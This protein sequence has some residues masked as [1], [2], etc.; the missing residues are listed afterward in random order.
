M[1]PQRNIGIRASNNPVFSGLSQF[2]RLSGR[3][4]TCQCRWPRFH[5]WVGKTPWRRKWQPAPVFLARESHGQRSLVGYSPWDRK[6]LDMTERTCSLTLEALHTGNPWA[7]TNGEDCSPYWP[8]L[9]AS[10]DRR[11]G[12]SIL[13]CT[14]DRLSASEMRIINLGLQRRKTEMQ[15][16]E[17]LAQ[18]HMANGEAKQ[19]LG[20]GFFAHRNQ[21]P[22]VHCYPWL[23]LNMFTGKQ[24]RPTTSP[25]FQNN[26]GFGKLGYIS[27]YLLYSKLKWRYLKNVCNF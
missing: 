24:T 7:Q 4:H 22:W 2:R 20:Q 19:Y 9:G 12:L 26:W 18:R 23:I 27:C 15:T 17:R 11:A 13:A 5:P 21:C 10:L 16:K 3:E 6:E 25:A 1:G 8:N 14:L